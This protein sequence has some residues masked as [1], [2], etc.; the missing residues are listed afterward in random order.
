[1]TVMLSSPSLATFASVLGVGL[2]SLIG[3]A[4]FVW[5]EKT[6]RGLIFP[7]VSFSTGALLGDVFLHLFPEIGTSDYPLPRQLQFV[8]GGILLSFIIEK[9]I[10]WQ[11][12]HEHGEH[13]DEHHHSVG[14]M[15][16][17]GDA[18]HNFIDGAL[19]A[20]SFL[21]SIPVGIATAV[22]VA[23]HEIPHE[24]GNFAILLYS[25]FTRRQAIVYNVI[26]GL[27]AFVGA[28]AV[29]ASHVALPLI[30]QLLL[31]VAA[32]NLLYIASVDL[33]P[34]LHKERRLAHNFLQLL[35]LLA[36]MAIMQLLK[37]FG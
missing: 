27:V 24:I 3:V 19:I 33:I 10:H 7:F 31:P 20:A 15:S 6:I 18:A 17:V 23:L 16:L 9:F 1:M 22:A 29:L 37:V 26:S 21:V 14:V 2:L 30:G 13:C 12:C 28:G 5:E 36:G 11:H 8:L 34:E 25:G 4:T 32:G 35:M